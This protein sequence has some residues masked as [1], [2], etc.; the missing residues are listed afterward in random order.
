MVHCLTPH[1]GF[2]QHV[3]VLR[4]F[5]T[6]TRSWQPRRWGAHWGLVHCQILICE[7][8]EMAACTAI[9]TTLH[10]AQYN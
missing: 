4:D 10:S 7:D 5:E 1:G 3:P 2:G 8:L 9:P 6:H